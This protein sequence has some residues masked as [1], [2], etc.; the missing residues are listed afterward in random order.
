MKKVCRSLFFVLLPMFAEAQY[1]RILNNP[2][3]I[4]AA[5]IEV[6]YYL[7]PP[8]PSDSVQQND[9][10]FWKS[11]DP[12]NRTP[13]EGGEMLME[14]I[15]TAARS[16]EWLAWQ[17]T[18]E[19]IKVENLDPL[20]EGP[21]WQ[22]ADT[23]RQ[24]SV[25]EV[26]R[27]VEPPGIAVVINPETGEDELKETPNTSDIA[28]W[29][30][31]RAKQLLY[32]DKKKGDF[33][34]LTCA[35]A[36]VRLVKRYEFDQSTGEY[37]PR[38]SDYVPFWLKMPDFSQ[39][40]S[41]KQPS[42]NDSNI[43]WAAQIKTLGNSPELENLRPLKNLK[44]PVMQVLLDR[45]RTDAKFK[46]YDTTD[47]PIRFEARHD[48]LFSSDTVTTF[49]PETYEEKIEISHREFRAE[50]FARLRLIQNWYW[51]DRQRRLVMR[52]QSFAPII[53]DYR[54]IGNSRCDL[55]LFYRRKK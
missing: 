44:P 39:K 53:P 48:M 3:V 18:G 45:F 17:F 4:W 42:V 28:T 50:D 21:A 22:L 11:F 47:E 15:L 6:T 34:L 35:I 16:G 14:K 20:G 30:A 33:Q 51:D 37:K 12:K 9:I 54:I 19:S 7:R 46:A 1:E 31:I 5:E 49:N 52:L 32:F 29:Y 2:D 23:V 41:R 36:P 10:I 27:T 24:L 38:L 55:P 26:S 8:L 13:Y 25:Y 40:K 43:S